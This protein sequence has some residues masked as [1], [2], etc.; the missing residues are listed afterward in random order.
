MCAS[1]PLLLPT[2]THTYFLVINYNIKPTK[3]EAAGDRQNVCVSVSV[4]LYHS[5]QLFSLPAT[6]VSGGGA[7]PFSK[8]VTIIS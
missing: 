3:N 1:L 6:M 4:L 5:I 7:T 2:I 8:I